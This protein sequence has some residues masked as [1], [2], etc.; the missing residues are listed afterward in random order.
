MYPPQWS[1]TLSLSSTPP[2]EALVSSRTVCINI[3][4][5]LFE[6][7]FQGSGECWASTRAISGVLEQPAGWK[8]EEEA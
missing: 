6:T 2:V 1:L 3:E 5:S 7:R 4:C 8:Q